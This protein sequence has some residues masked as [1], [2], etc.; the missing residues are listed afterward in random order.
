MLKSFIV[1]C[2][3]ESTDEAVLA[4]HQKQID[5]MQNLLTQLLEMVRSGQLDSRHSTDIFKLVKREMFGDYTFQLAETF[6]ASGTIQA[7]SA[8]TDL[9]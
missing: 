3:I 8:T 5:S 2:Q 6:L 1:R 7:M 4:R 9:D